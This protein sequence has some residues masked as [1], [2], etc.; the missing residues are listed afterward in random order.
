MGENFRIVC[1]DNNCTFLDYRNLT[2]AEFI[3]VEDIPGDSKPEIVI[4]DCVADEFGALLIFKFD[5][6]NKKF[7]RVIGI[8]SISTEFYR[9]NLTEFFYDS[10]C[11]NQGGC[12]STLFKFNNDSCI[13]LASVYV[14]FNEKPLEYYENM[15]RNSAERIKI[16][17]QEAINDLLRQFWSSKSSKY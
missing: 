12:R 5:N 1:G 6:T 14:I 11:F 17:K 16:D 4:D 13:R 15:F 9:L 3:H 10:F 8:D 7:N 2:P